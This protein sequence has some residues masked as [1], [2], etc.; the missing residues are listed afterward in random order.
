MNDAPL[1]QMSHPSQSIEAT[2]GA[3]SHDTHST[4][5]T[6]TCICGSLFRERGFGEAESLKAIYC[7]SSE[8][9]CGGERGSEKVLACPLRFLT[10]SVPIVTNIH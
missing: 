3:L 8:E 7:F 1:D 2:E 4:L 10:G 6:H 9:N 5:G